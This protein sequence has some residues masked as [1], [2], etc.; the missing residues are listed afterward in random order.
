MAPQQNEGFYRDYYLPTKRLLETALA[1]GLAF[2]AQRLLQLRCD[3]AMLT[4]WS[5]CGITARPA[6]LARRTR[7]LETR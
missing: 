1:V 5:G 6:R 3:A 7:S 2:W 4:C